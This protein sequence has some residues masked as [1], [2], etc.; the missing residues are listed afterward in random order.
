VRWDLTQR[1][2]EK[3]HFTYTDDIRAAPIKR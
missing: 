1:T 3:L 2:A